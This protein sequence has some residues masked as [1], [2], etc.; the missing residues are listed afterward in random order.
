MLSPDV[1]QTA[2]NT[3]IQ[4]EDVRKKYRGEGKNELN[5]CGNL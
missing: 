4:T 3:A 2:I 1:Y 5:M